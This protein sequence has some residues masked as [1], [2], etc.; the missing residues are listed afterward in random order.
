MSH[1]SGYSAGVLQH[2]NAGRVRLFA[3]LLDWLYAL[4]LLALPQSTPSHITLV[5]AQGFELQQTSPRIAKLG[6][7]RLPGE[8]ALERMKR[9]QE[10]LHCT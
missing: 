5:P 9:T 3:A 6:S 8:M 2:R 7:D 1:S 10:L 4:A